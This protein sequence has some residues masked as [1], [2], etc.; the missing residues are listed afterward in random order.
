LG[1]ILRI[2]ITQTSEG[3]NY[4]IPKDNP[5]AGNLWGYSEEI[6]AYGFRNPWRFSF[7]TATGQLW[8]GD[9]GQDR[10]EEIDIVESGKNYGWNLMEGTVC[11]NP[12]IECNQTGLTL[13]IFNYTHSLGNAIIGGY[14]YHG[15]VNTNLEGAYIY[16]D[17]GSGRIWA[18]QLS[19]ASLSN[20]QLVDSGLN[21]ASF[22]IDQNGELYF[23]AYDGKIYKLTPTP[24]PE[25]SRTSVLISVLAAIMLT[26]LVAIITIKRQR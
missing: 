19:G 3:R 26:I 6:Y 17:Y 11:Y 2:D 4:S 8:V 12:A 16:G 21:I 15:K 13:P 5:F 9:V 10:I 14:V 24:I 23:S 20:L 25:F 1:K 7:D 18:L 22:D